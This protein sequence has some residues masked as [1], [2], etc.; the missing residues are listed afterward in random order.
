MPLKARASAQTKYAAR[1]EAVAG[2]SIHAGFVCGRVRYRAKLEMLATLQ[3]PNGAHN[4]IVAVSG[5][6]SR[7]KHEH[8]RQT[9]PLS[10]NE[11][12]AIGTAGDRPLPRLPFERPN[13]APREVC[14]DFTHIADTKHGR[15][16]RWVGIHH[17]GTGV[18]CDG[19]KP[20]ASHW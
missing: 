2:G 19:R 15:M 20:T 4:G 10:T 12:M 14:L 11:S 16:R 7:H 17:M 8:R 6:A 1:H 13:R 18:V 5:L 9:G 3:P